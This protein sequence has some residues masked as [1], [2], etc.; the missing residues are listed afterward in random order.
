MFVCAAVVILLMTLFHALILTK[1]RRWGAF[2]Y[3]RTGLYASIGLGLGLMPLISLN[4]EA[5][6]KYYVSP[7]VLPTISLAV[8]SVLL[9]T[10]VHRPSRLSHKS[11]TWRTE[12][13][14]YSSLSNPPNPTENASYEGWHNGSQCPPNYI[15]LQSIESNGGRRS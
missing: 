3:V 10:H 12:N 5:E 7:W 1:K 2:D 14:A 9:L 4:E 13:T 11:T 15:P 8:L 6:Y